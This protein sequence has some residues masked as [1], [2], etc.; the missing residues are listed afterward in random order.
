MK[1]IIAFVKKETVLT[2]AWVLAVISAFI[3]TP[4]AKYIDYIDLKSLG[5][6]WSLMIIMEGLKKLGIFKAIGMLLLNRTHKAWQLA[7]ILVALCFFFSMFITN[8]VALLTFVPFAIFMLEMCNRTDLLIP[9]LVLQTIAANL[10]S[11]LTPIG[12]PQN[13][14][15]YG[16]SGISL[17]DFLMLMLPFTGLTALLLIINIFILPGK[18]KA[19]HMISSDDSQSET[20]DNASTGSLTSENDIFSDKRSKVVCL[21]YAA[22]FL[23]SLLVVARIL[24]YYIL[25]AIVLICCLTMDRYPLIHIDYALLLTFVGFFIF[26]GNLGN[27]APVKALFTSS[28]GG[29]EIA[30][31]IIASQLISNVPAAL[32]LSGFSTNLKNLIIG[33]NLGGL[34]TLIASMASLISFKLL[35][36]SHNELKGKYFIR[37]TITN[38]IYLAVL[39]LLAIL[40]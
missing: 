36:H 19:I 2:I 4:S 13:L 38:I 31:G 10:G 11:M 24:P 22:L 34:G 15:L 20:S 18:T 35:A 21:M 1:K 37:F 16:I 33:V 7:S 32:L 3:I 17:G 9:T 40:I 29:N 12:N 25:V 39:V 6:L 5:T 23:L 26:T 27:I 28:V 30:A 14:Y 8:D